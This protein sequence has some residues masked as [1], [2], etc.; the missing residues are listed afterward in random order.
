[1]RNRMTSCTHSPDLVVVPREQATRPLSEGGLGIVEIPDKV[2]S[3]GMRAI[4]LF[5]ETAVEY[6]RLK[7]K[8]CWIV[9]AEQRLEAE[10]NVAEIFKNGWAGSRLELKNGTK[11]EDQSA[12]FW[13]MCSKGTELCNGYGRTSRRTT[14]GMDGSGFV[15]MVA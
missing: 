1:M 6:D 5:R 4:E 2:R 7:E 12:R 9:L 14:K 11:S 3:I 15:Q 10:L 13:G 8:L